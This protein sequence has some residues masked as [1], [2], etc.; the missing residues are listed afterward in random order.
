MKLKE[1]NLEQVL[2]AP[3]RDDETGRAF[4]RVLS[5]CLRRL[6]E[7]AER[8]LLLPNVQRL[9]EEILDA[10]AR[11]LHIPWYDDGVARSVKR[12]VVAQS[13]RVN[14]R[15]GTPYAVEQVAAAYFGEAVVEEWWEYGAAPYS[16]R[17]RTPNIE[18]VTENHKVFQDV[19]AYTQNLRSVFDGVVVDQHI[20]KANIYLGAVVTA[21]ILTTIPGGTP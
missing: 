11:E 10:L 18:A 16:F 20:P 19:I 2:C 14:M 4:A 7:Q 17:V 1:A 8:V 5:P 12:E 9:P 6:A 21:S 15:L 13:D 3:L